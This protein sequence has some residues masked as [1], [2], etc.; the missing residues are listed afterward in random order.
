MLP[1]QQE[2]C[3]LRDAVRTMM[4]QICKVGVAYNNDVVIEGT[5]VVTVDRQKVIVIHFDDRLSSHAAAATLHAGSSDAANVS[6]ASSSAAAAPG[7]D[8]NPVAEGFRSAISELS[9]RHYLPAGLATS[10]SKAGWFAG[11]TT[12]KMMN[13]LNELNETLNER[14]AIDIDSDEHD[15]SFDDIDLADVANC[16]GAVQNSL[17]PVEQPVFAGGGGAGAVKTCRKVKDAKNVIVIEDGELLEPDCDVS[18]TAGDDYST[19]AELKLLDGFASRCLLPAADCESNADASDARSLTGGD[20]RRG[21][22]SEMLSCETCGWQARTNSQLESHLVTRHGIVDSRRLGRPIAH[23]ACPLCGKRFRFRAQLD[24]HRQCHA[25]TPPSER[26]HRCRKC[27]N[28][29]SQAQSLAL[30]SQVHDKN[31]ELGGS[32][33]SCVV[34]NK[35]YANK[36]L[37]QKHIVYMHER[38]AGFSGDD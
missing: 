1:A 6:S 35:S 37:F 23:T 4:A 33:L 31:V 9:V 12:S 32:R 17:P 2:G 25:S 34:C 36:V 24:K 30:H 15:A 7:V 14:V 22:E 10:C 19:G 27:R 21:F 29:Y 3:L 26:L 18:E 8:T 20:G 16:G 5:V 38:I 13:C 11:S 28:A